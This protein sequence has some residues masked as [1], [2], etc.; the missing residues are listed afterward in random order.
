MGIVLNPNNDECF[1]AWKEGGAY[2]NGVPI[3]V[4]TTD[5]LQ[6]SLISTGF[7]YQDYSK[8]QSYFKAFNF[9]MKNT[10]GIRRFGAAAL[11]LAYVACGR[12]GSLL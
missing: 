5:K 1:Y 4:S 3:Q 2:L 7:P 9:F 8:E 12:Y 10:R 11:D 6:K